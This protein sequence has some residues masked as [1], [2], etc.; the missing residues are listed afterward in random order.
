MKLHVPYCTSNLVEESAQIK[1]K[2][3]TTD[4]VTCAKMVMDFFGPNAAQ[5]MSEL[6]NYGNTLGV[7]DVSPFVMI[8]SLV[9]LL[10]VRGI[11]AT[12]EYFRN[13][14]FDFFL[15]TYVQNLYDIEARENGIATIIASIAEGVP[16]IALLKDHP[17]VLF[18][19]ENKNG[20]ITGFHYHDPK[21]ERGE[22]VFIS[23]ADFRATWT[24][25]AILLE[26]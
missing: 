8:D 12:K 10:K 11:H 24:R 17:V 5:E 20:Q 2:T 7:C 25:T 1:T 6:I 9:I 19:Y 4:G 13:N 21:G 26:K 15:S 23:A 3:F 18:G 22:A 16:V 14:S